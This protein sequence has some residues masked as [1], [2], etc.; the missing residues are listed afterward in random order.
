MPEDVS[1]QGTTGTSLP[2][3]DRGSW[4]IEYVTKEKALIITVTDYHAGPLRFQLTS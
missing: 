2:A 3:E 1:S 4:E